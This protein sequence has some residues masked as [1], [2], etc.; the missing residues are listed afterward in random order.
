MYNRRRM[1]LLDGLHTIHLYS[2]IFNI[3]LPLLEWVIGCRTYSHTHNAAHVS[4]LAHYFYLVYCHH[5]QALDVIESLQCGR[6]RLSKNSFSWILEFNGS[7]YGK[8][9][10]C[11]SGHTWKSRSGMAFIFRTLLGRDVNCVPP[12]YHHHHRIKLDYKKC[13]NHKLISLLNSNMRMSFLLWFTTSNTLKVDFE[14][15]SLE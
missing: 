2:T 12:L 10:I 4:S 9:S 14:R 7:F 11:L 13:W 6:L 15:D 3:H 1:A 5:Y 8:E